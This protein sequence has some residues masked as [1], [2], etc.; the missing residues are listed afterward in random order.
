MSIVEQHYGVK[1]IIYYPRGFYDSMIKKDFQGYFGWVASYTSKKKIKHIKW[2][3][4]QFSDKI[5]VKGIDAV[6]DGNHYNGSLED[7]KKI[8]LQ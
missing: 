2:D 8:V 7:L 4:H 6:V 3:F 5:Q 1:P